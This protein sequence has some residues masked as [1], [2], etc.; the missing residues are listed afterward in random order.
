VISVVSSTDRGDTVEV[1]AIGRE[2]LAAGVA[3][4]VPAQSPFDLVVQVPGNALRLD[5]TR[6]REHID[7]SADF[8]QRWFEYLHMLITQ[9]AQTAV[10]NRYHGSARRL[11]RWLLTVADRA[12]AEAF[13]LTHEF[14]ATMVGGNRPRVSV[15][16]RSLREQH[17]VEHRRGQLKI[18]D[19]EGLTKAAC[20]CYL[21]VATATQKSDTS[22]MGD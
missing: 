1:A 5:G 18:L 6:L 21:R 19:R 2:G 12:D 22:L 17:L 10:C 20:E 8:R 7:R 13:P 16:M 4:G 14:A 3:A 9:M 11:A 15:A